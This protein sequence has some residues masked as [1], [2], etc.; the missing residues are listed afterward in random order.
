MRCMKVG[1]QCD[2]VFSQPNSKSKVRTP[3][4]DV[5]SISPDMTG[6][7]MSLVAIE[8]SITHLI[9]SKS[10]TI[11]CMEGSNLTNIGFL[12]HFVNGSAESILNPKIKAVMKTGLI[13]TAFTVCLTF[14]GVNRQV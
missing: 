7:N 9:G 12:N 10:T 4:V 3:C 8:R 1:I 11:Q 2:Y 5:G 14:E 13:R 6:T